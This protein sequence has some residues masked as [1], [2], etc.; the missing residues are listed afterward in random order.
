[1]TLGTDPEAGASVLRAHPEQWTMRDRPNSTSEL[2]A[3]MAELD[4]ARTAVEA[5]LRESDNRLACRVADIRNG[6]RAE[7]QSLEAIAAASRAAVAE[8]VSEFNLATE[9]A[10]RHESDRLPRRQAGAFLDRLGSNIGA[11]VI[12][13]LGDHE[14]ASVREIRDGVRAER[15][16]LA[17]WGSLLATMARDGAVVRTGPANQPRYARAPNHAARPR[18]EMRPR[19]S[20]APA[21][22]ATSTANGHPPQVPATR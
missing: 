7:I 12:A 15:A 20:A 21:W 14:A 11:R 1:M 2:I 3:R 4:R 5:R 16:P 22:A 18:A 8:A 10:S 6:A 13:F 9:S 19:I 17:V